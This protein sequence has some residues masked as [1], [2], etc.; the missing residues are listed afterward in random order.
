[1]NIPPTHET[2]A[3]YQICSPQGF[4]HESRSGHRGGWRRHWCAYYLTLAGW[5][6][7]I[8]DQGAFGRGCSHGN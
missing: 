7:T 5:H 4:V 1:M 3:F 6:V 2:G 8:V